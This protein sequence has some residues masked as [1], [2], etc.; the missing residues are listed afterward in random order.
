MAWKRQFFSDQETPWV[1]RQVRVFVP[2]TSNV[3]FVRC[4]L[5]GTGQLV[6]DDASLTAEP[7]EPA[8]EL[9]LNTNL[10]ADPGF[11]K[12]DVNGWEYSLPPYAE[13]YAEPDSQ[14]VHSGRVLGAVQLARARRSS[15][16]A[17][18]CARCSAT[19]A[20]RTSACG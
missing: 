11:E 5:I 17:P 3:V 7:A 19:G 6:I 13:M 18:A 14:I 8:T 16:A 15:P 1:K 9:P 4:G 12:H 2:P 10:L 20:S